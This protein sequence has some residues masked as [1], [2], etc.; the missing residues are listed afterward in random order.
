[1]TIYNC[2]HTSEHVL[3]SDGVLPR[4]LG[5]E[6][7]L[8]GPERGPRRQARAV[9]VPLPPSAT[10]VRADRFED[11]GATAEYVIATMAAVG[12]AGLLVAIMRSDEVK[13]ILLS[14]VRDALQVPL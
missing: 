9:D 2:Q 5:A 4:N 11:G 3:P 13:G 6:S 8:R 14:V 12:F 10:T 1:M 7:R